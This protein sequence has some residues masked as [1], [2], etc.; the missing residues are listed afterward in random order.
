MHEKTIGL[1]SIFAGSLPAI[2]G[3]I[4]FNKAGFKHR[5]LVLFLLY[6]FLSDVVKWQLYE[7]NYSF[8]QDS[9]FYIYALIESVFFCWF[10]YQSSDIKPVSQTA[11]FLIFIFSVLWVFCYI[12]FTLLT[13]KES[14]DEALFNTVY[15]MTVALLASYS[16]LRLTRINEPL[17]SIPD[18]WFLT[19]IFFFCL[20]TFF[21]DAF[22]Q[23]PHMHRFWFIHDVF[24]IMTCFIYAYGFLK[25]ETKSGS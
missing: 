18:F 8:A 11:F 21:V 7:H 12:D 20:C 25:I 2:A 15:E 4:V 1:I 6:G 3:M 13:W 24:N 9:V 5:I 23:T 16:I 17:V 14:T 22:L 10:I 19:A